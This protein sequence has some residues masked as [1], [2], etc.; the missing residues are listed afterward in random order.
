MRGHRWEVRVYYEDTDLGGIV[1]YANYLKYLERG[2]TEALRGVGIDQVAMKAA[3]V[4]F[5][6]RRVVADYLA[7]ARFDEVVTVCTDLVGMSG[8]TVTLDQA[9]VR[10][11]TTLLRAQVVLA[12]MGADGRPR[13]LGPELRRALG[14]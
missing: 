1:Y 4:V 3:G 10:G 14:G 5:V 6:V 11:E 2:R 12:V 7:P 13:R 9:V 8:A